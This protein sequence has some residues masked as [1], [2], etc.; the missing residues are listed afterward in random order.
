[1]L[2][3]IRYHFS[4]KRKTYKYLAGQYDLSRYRVCALA[5]GRKAR[6]DREHMLCGELRT[7]GLLRNK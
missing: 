6:R 7:R 1:M 5:R 3:I 2:N 4:S